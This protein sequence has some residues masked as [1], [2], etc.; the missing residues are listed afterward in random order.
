[1]EDNLMS[2]CFEDF[3]IVTK[4]EYMIIFSKVFYK[5]PY[6]RLTCNIAKSRFKHDA[7]AFSNEK[8]EMERLQLTENIMPYF[9]FMLV[10]DAVKKIVYDK[11][12]KKS[13]YEIADHLFMYIE[14]DDFRDAIMAMDDSVDYFSLNVLESLIIYTLL[15]Y[16]YR[17][18]DDYS[19]YVLPVLAE[20][21]LPMIEEDG[22]LE[23]L[24]QLIEA[25]PPHDETEAERAR[26]ENVPE[27]DVRDR[28]VEAE[29]EIHRLKMRVTDLEAELKDARN[30]DGSDGEDEAS[31][32]FYKRKMQLGLLRSLM[33]RAGINIG[34]N[35]SAAAILISN[36]L[37]ISNYK[38]IQK[39]LSEDPYLRTADHG[40]ACAEVNGILQELA[41]PFKIECKAS[42]SAQKGEEPVKSYA[43][44]LKSYKNTGE[45]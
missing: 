3:D 15:Y 25:L 20:N 19:K 31:P 32:R 29:E 37:H 23:R 44:I 13:I 10:K 1:M 27:K 16:R 24:H 12:P 6:L 33:G 39:M 5:I 7:V 17:D 30:D 35:K 21:F 40:E 28:L 8:D 42:K 18:V 41:S 11:N 45:Q 38:S 34:K 14:E 4:E 26:L 9:C 2:E 22:G 43:E 36:L